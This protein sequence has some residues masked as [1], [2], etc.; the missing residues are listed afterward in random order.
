[1]VANEKSTLLRAGLLDGVAIAL[2][3]PRLADGAELALAPAG[4]AT[5][6]HVCITLGAAVQYCP[7]ELDGEPEQRELLTDA[8]VEHACSALGEPSMLVVDA[9]ALAASLSGREALVSSLQGAWD[10][11][12]A[13][14]N[15]ACIAPGRGGRIVLLAP[16][17]SSDG[18]A[19]A[20]RAGLENLARTLST[21]W[22]RYGVSS[23]A[24]APS[25]DTAPEDLGEIVA[26]LASAAGAYFSGCL[27]DLRG[28]SGVRG[29]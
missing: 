1:M 25:P 26:Y 8:A 14:A 24:I 4:T 29:A 15:R 10:V 12:R 22:A 20:A 17:P 28:V 7:L 11:A 16:A 23:V 2:A 5:I 27:L 9:G 18:H 21:E 3:G 19:D 13:F 6:G